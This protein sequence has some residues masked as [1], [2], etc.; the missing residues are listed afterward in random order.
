MYEKLINFNTWDSRLVGWLADAKF[1]DIAI[2]EDGD[3]KMYSERSP[4]LWNNDRMNNP[5]KKVKAGKEFNF[6][7]ITFKR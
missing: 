1:K 2:L 4:S 7:G 3:L 5:F 6:L